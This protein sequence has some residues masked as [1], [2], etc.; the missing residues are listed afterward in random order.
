MFTKCNEIKFEI[1]FKNEVL[2]LAGMFLKIKTK[3]TSLK[4]GPK[5]KK[6]QGKLKN[7]LR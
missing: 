5:K 7:I 1:N 6:S 3:N 4:K 2:E